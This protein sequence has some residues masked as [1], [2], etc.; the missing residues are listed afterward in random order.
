MLELKNNFK[1]H[2]SI[3]YLVLLVAFIL[4]SSLV[5]KRP[6]FFDW[7]EWS[8]IINFL[9]TD[10]INW[11]FQ[12][13]LGHIN[14]VG[15]FFYSLELFI[16]K[17]KYYLYVLTN[18]ILHTINS[19]IIYDVVNNLVKLKNLSLVTT[20]IYFFS[21]NH[22]ENLLWGMQISVFLS[23]FFT[24][25]ILRL[26]ILNKFKNKIDLS[27]IIILIF[28]SSFS[29]SLAISIPT[30]IIIL[31]SL[32]Y[33]FKENL[34]SIIV[35][36]LIQIIIL[37]IYL[38][39]SNMQFQ[40]VHKGAATNQFNL[41]DYNFK[42]FERSILHLIHSVFFAPVYFLTTISSSL[43]NNE[44]DVILTSFKEF[45]L[46]H[47]V[48]S[49]KFFLLLITLVFIY[50]FRLK[51]NYSFFYSLFLF[52]ILSVPSTI[53]ISIGKTYNYETIFQCRYY[54]YNGVFIII[55]VLQFMNEKLINIKVKKYTIITFITFLIW[56][57]IFSYN[58]LLHSKYKNNTIIVIESYNKINQNHK[59]ETSIFNPLAN[60]E[61]TLKQ[62]KTIHNF[63]K[64]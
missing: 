49:R 56:N 52:F 17:D 64:R 51:A 50:N 60:P 14:P 18:I 26:V 10:F 53:L 32:K 4:Y 46:F 42:N 58:Y 20:L 29:F 45:D 40:Y 34:E 13:H 27:R 30:F 21:W 12:K 43:I 22:F 61:L 59:P 62:A 2:K 47:F 41:T 3:I 8:I 1:I 23:T 7:D 24:L 19:F 38:S 48:G 11:L 35:L 57:L 5:L 16:F 28:C 6:S 33:G 39:I 55:L 37:V 36:I 31:I 25:I 54:S 9:E 63:M 15:K 44:V